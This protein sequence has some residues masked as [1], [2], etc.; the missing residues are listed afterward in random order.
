[1]GSCIERTDVNSC[2]CTVSYN[3][4]GTTTKGKTDQCMLIKFFLMTDT[5]KT[6]IA[7]EQRDEDSLVAAAKREAGADAR[8]IKR[9]ARHDADSNLAKGT[10][11]YLCQ[12]R[13]L[14]NSCWPS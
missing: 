2:S 1:M 14:H 10:K 7:L 11:R 4:K 8:L 3:G 12:A 13:S 6:Q 9:A 5:S